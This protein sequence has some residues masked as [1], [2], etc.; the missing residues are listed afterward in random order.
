MDQFKMD[1]IRPKTL[2][3]LEEAYLISVLSKTLQLLGLEKHFMNR[4]L[5]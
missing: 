3:F 4:N 2:D 1:T 5:I